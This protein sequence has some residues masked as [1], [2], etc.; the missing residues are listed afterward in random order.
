MATL[1]QRVLQLLAQHPGLSD[2]EI[3]DLLLA[4]GAAQQ[5]I[6]VACRSLETRGMVRRIKHPGRRIGNYLCDSSFPGQISACLNPP[7]GE[8]DP[9]DEDSIKQVLDNWLRARGWETS[10]AWGREHGID[11]EAQQQNLRWVIEVKGRGSRPEMRVNYF[12]SMLGE[13]LQR[14]D[15]PTATYSIALPDMPEFHRLWQRLPALVKARTGISA[16][17]VNT[18]GMVSYQAS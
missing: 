8:A 17:F 18:S 12:I 2:R 14:M 11:I 9:L 7:V 16:L 1:Q 15:D 5:P 13:L 6:N 10:I 3:A 4:P